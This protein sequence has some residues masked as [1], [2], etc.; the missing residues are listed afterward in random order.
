MRTLIVHPQDPS[1]SFL[2][3]IY[4]TI[5]DKTVITGGVSKYK[6]RQLI[7]NHDRIIMLGHGSPWGLFAVGKF[8]IVGSYVIDS[9]FT[10]LLSSKQ[11]NIFIWCYA[12]HFVQRYGLSGFY[13]GMFVS[14][15]T[16]AIYCNLLDVDLKQIEESNKSFASIV[17]RNILQ[18]LNVLYE[19]VIQK[20]YGLLAETNP[21][22]KFNVE[23]L[24]YNH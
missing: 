20:E 2:E 3:P 23:R 1:T 12:N 4:G 16:E 19:N 18:P 11:E 9:S 10:D 22:A 7:K 5:E 13:S 17:S 14:E 8:P 24:Y 6:L 15:L 21:I